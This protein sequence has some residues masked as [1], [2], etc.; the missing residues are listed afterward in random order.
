[1]SDGLLGR[2]R[3]ECGCYVSSSWILHDPSLLIRQ[4]CRK[5]I[6]LDPLVFISIVAAFLNPNLLFI[7][8][9]P[10][11]IPYESFGDVA[12]Y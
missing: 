12:V 4:H 9:R 3:A 8:L 1:M 6:Y 11:D 5:R 2:R 7:C 10:R